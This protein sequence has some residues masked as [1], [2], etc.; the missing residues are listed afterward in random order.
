MR[1][2]HNRRIYIVREIRLHNYLVVKVLL[3]ILS[4]LV[5]T[6]AIVDR[7]YLYLWPIGIWHLWF[8]GKW[9]DNIEDNGNPVFIGL[10]DQTNMGIG[11]EGSD[12]AKPLVGCLGVLE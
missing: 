4:A 12:H 2:F 11:G 8:F 6:M 7:E 5:S 9:L 3:Q 10:S 1:P